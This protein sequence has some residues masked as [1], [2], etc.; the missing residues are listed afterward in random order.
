[1]KSLS[2]NNI[3]KIL[4]NSWFLTGIILILFLVT[5]RYIYGWDDQTLEIPLLKHLID[6]QLFQG[7]YYV[8]SLKKNFTSYLYPVLA[9]VITVD[10]IPAVYYFLYII[11]R[12]FL[13]FFSLKLWKHISG[14]TWIAVAATLMSFLI[15][16]TEE[17][18]YRTFSH[19]E[20]ALAIIMAGIYYLYK[21][22]VVL[23]AI[24]FGIAANF[25]ALYALFPMTY[26]GMYLL[27]D[28]K[29]KKLI[30]SCTAFILSALPFLIWMINQ[31]IHAP[32][33]PPGFYDG[34][35]ELFLIACPQNFLFQ[36]RSLIQV[37]S[38][39]STAMLALGPYLFLIALY[40]F[41]MI[42][43]ES[44]RRSKQ[45]QAFCICGFG[46]LIVSFIFS[47]PI[48]SRF[49]INLNLIRNA[50]YLNF[51][52]MGYTT[53]WITRKVLN[54]NLSQAYWAAVLLGL[55]CLK[56]IL[57]VFILFVVSLAIV[58][59]RQETVENKDW[60]DIALRI[61]DVGLAAAMLYI[62][63][64]HFEFTGSKFKFLAISIAAVSVMYLIFSFI[65]RANLPKWL[66]LSFIIIP[67]TTLF[68]YFCVLHYNYIRV[69]TKGG[70]FWQLQRN[71]EEMQGFVKA[72]TP[73]DALIMVPYNMEM[74]GFRIGSER[75]IIVSY[76]DCGIVG[77]DYA[78]LKEWE[79]RV[80]DIE[81]F[82]VIPDGPIQSA[83]VN[84][85]SKYKAD[86]IVFMRF[87]APKSS[88]STLV[89]L[90]ENE[91]FVLFKV[92]R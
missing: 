9:R 16:R 59:R 68:I 22:K 50:Q 37:F 42:F 14:N 26:L 47:Y 35:L 5:N 12:Y 73:K 63:Y 84:G 62:L 31:K 11:S 21:D 72:N 4:Q 90:H 86:Y 1:M 36:E 55:L 87:L 6:P 38:T 43:N 2:G 57:G 45:S 83:L 33:V 8:E 48:P 49:V 19:Q 78:A 20:F 54:T 23:A 3:K 74:C 51:I 64:Q 91:I 13:F 89:K 29:F 17:F 25:N 60:R 15:G 28:G 30:F 10:Q 27:L 75:K 52:L 56:D 58:I 88:N 34:W 71:W 85:L 76:R 18:L 41:N 66:N 92:N 39:F 69:T 61:V 79:R 24:L 40:A 67:L 32:A 80:K 65:R 82:K 77:F 7:D 53:I 44:F 81:H 46:L 70:G